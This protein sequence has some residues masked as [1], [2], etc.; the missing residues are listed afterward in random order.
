MEGLVL[1]LTTPQCGGE[2]FTWRSRCLVT[3]KE[4]HRMLKQSG[5]FLLNHPR[6]TKIIP[7]GRVTKCG[8]AYQHAVPSKLMPSQPL[9]TPHSSQCRLLQPQSLTQTLTA[10][11]TSSFLTKP[12]QIIPIP[13][14]SHFQVSP[15]GLRSPSEPL[16]CSLPT[17]S[18]HWTFGFAFSQLITDCLVLW[19]ILWVH[20]FS[21]QIYSG[22][23][24]GAFVNQVHTTQN[25][26]L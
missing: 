23:L 14:Y 26:V 20:V 1:L 13:S 25:W 9:S 15:R 17:I 8:L 16:T 19:T 7:S 24:E 21:F 22:F 5:I 11:H 12:S 3:I 10:T 4:E 6:F 18:L 2:F